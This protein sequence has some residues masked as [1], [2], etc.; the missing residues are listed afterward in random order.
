MTKRLISIGAAFGALAVIFGAFGAHALKN[1]LSADALQAYETGVRYQLIHAILL[2]ALG[3]QTKID[4]K[5][6]GRFIVV[7]I[8]LFSFSI[9]LLS[10]K[11]LLNLPFLKYLGPITPVGGLLLILSWVFLLIKSLK[12]KSID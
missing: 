7:G 4:V 5:L 6:I 8:I 11:D 12:L 10:L 3:F 2:V 1:V 9:Y